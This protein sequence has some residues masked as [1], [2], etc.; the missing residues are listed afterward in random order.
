MSEKMNITPVEAL[1]FRLAAQYIERIA[2]LAVDIARQ[3]NE[4][5][6]SKLIKKIDPIVTQIKDML[7]KSV[8]NLFT[9][10]SEK[11]DC[12]IEAEQ[13]L[14]EE[15]SKLRQF[16]VSLHGEDTHAHLYVTDRLLRIG[17]AAKDITDL[18]LP[19]T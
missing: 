15:T 8:S 11:V 5:L 19:H 3:T 17:E 1:D 13:R 4:P 7:S 9:F 12:V 18:A 10:D 14:I 2:D 6:S 16:L